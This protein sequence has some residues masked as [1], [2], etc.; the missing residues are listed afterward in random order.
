[1]RWLFYILFASFLIVSVYLYPI[2]TKENACFDTAQSE[3]QDI[4]FNVATRGLSKEDLC[5]QRRASIHSLE[6]CIGAVTVGDQF[7]QYDT[8]IID[9]VVSII[10]Y[11]KNLKTLINEHNTECSDYTSFQVE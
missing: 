9:S 7:A 4:K 6:N 2:I 11:D 10:R 1:M 5:S 3:I 8:G